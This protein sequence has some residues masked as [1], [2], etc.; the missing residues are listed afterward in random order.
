MRGRVRKRSGGEEYAGV[1]RGGGRVGREPGQS[2][3]AWPRRNGGGVAE[4]GVRVCVLCVLR[5]GG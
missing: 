3:E 1:V 4:G 5:G 2:T